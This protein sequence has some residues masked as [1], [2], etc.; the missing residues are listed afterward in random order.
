M[1]GGLFRGLDVGVGVLQGG[2]GFRQVVQACFLGFTLRV[3][4]IMH[5]IVF[6]HLIVC[7]T[8]LVFLFPLVYLIILICLAIL[9][10]FR[11]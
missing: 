8:P 11:I 7:L 1:R 5:S 10:K 4:F 2:F 3:G 6:I 9:L